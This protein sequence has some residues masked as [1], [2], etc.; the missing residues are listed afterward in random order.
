M[1][2][3]FRIDAGRAELHERAEKAPT[4][5]ATSTLHHIALSLPRAEQGAVEAW[6]SKNE[7]EYQVVEFAWIG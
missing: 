5:G 6:Y 3:L 7:L 4:G 1:L 2:A